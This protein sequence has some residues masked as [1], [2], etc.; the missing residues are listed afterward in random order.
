[1]PNFRLF[2]W[3][4]NEFYC[5]ENRTITASEIWRQFFPRLWTKT[6]RTRNQVSVAPVDTWRRFPRDVWPRDVEKGTHLA[7]GIC[8]SLWA[9][10]TF[11]PRLSTSRLWKWAAHGTKCLQIFW[12][13]VQKRLQGSPCAADTWCRVRPLSDVSGYKTLEKIIPKA[14]SD[15]FLTSQNRKPRGKLSWRLAQYCRNLVPVGPLFEVSRSKN[16]RRI[17]SKVRRLLQTPGAPFAR[18]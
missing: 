16:S 6:G 3:K 12:I 18:Y 13:F 17:V 8:N 15:P 5:P 14:R 10:E 2:G 1:M 9:L 11:S 7:A 4:L